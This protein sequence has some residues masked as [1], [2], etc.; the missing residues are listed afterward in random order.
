MQLVQDL[1]HLCGPPTLYKKLS[2]RSHR[3]VSCAWWPPTGWCPS[4]IRR[5]FHCS[6]YL[7]SQQQ[8]LSDCCVQDWNHLWS[9][10][11]VLAEAPQGEVTFEHLW[12]HPGCTAFIVSH[13]GLDITGCSKVTYLQHSASSYKEQ[14]ERVQQTGIRDLQYVRHYRSFSHWPK[15]P[16]TPVNIW[17]L[18]PPGSNN[19]AVVM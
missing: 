8:S 18:F 12:C 10:A 14:T 13:V 7:R 9:L 17:L 2:R 19:S 15:T 3:R 4:W 1:A 11:E 6:Y 5:T 16:L